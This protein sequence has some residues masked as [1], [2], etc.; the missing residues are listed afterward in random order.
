MIN[1][2]LITADHKKRKIKKK[3]KEDRKKKRKTHKKKHPKDSSISINTSKN[4]LGLEYRMNHVLQ[5]I[6]IYQTK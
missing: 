2:A 4:T 3:E 6:C 1:K 5:Y